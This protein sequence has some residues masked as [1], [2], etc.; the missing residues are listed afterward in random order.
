MSAVSDPAALSVLGGEITAALAAD[1]ARLAALADTAVFDETGEHVPARH[2]ALVP[3]PVDGSD[4]VV[5]F[6]GREDD[7]DSLPAIEARIAASDNELRAR[8][9][10]IRANPP[11]TEADA[12]AVLS[13]AFAASVTHLREHRRPAPRPNL[14]VHTGGAA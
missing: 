13:E 3:D 6:P 9:A 2:L 12:R 14:T 5:P 1:Q 11:T 10:A 7:P 8:A 4:V